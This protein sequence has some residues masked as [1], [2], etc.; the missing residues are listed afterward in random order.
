MKLVLFATLR[1]CSLNQTVR[2][3]YQPPARKTVSFNEITDNLSCCKGNNHQNSWKEIARNTCS[4]PSDKENEV[5]RNLILTWT[6]KSCDS[7][8]KSLGGMKPGMEDVQ[9]EG[10]PWDVGALN[11]GTAGL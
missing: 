10:K 8:K 3:I 11:N 5:H 6:K 4:L 2:T 1:N 9:R 7:A